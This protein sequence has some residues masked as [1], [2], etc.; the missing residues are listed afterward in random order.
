MAVSLPNGATLRLAATYGTAKTITA[1]SNASPAVASSTAHGFTAGSILEMTSGWARLNSR[2]VRVGTAPATDTFRLDGIDSTDTA[3]FPAAGGAGSARNVLT[4]VDLPQVLEFNTSGGET[5]FANYQFLESDTE[6][7]IP[8]GFSAMSIQV[9]I[10]DDP[11]LACY[12][13]L[14]AAS[15]SRRPIIMTLTLPNGS[16]ILY[17]CFVSFNE[18]PSLSKGNVMSVKP[19]FALIAQPVRY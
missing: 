15:N 2:A 4:W 19:S 8:S 5:Q 1:I 7:Q 10:A 13:V 14:R 17:N 6:Q 3:L 12:P 9:T 18:T 16:Q 11:T